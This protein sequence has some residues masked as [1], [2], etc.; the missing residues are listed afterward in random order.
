MHEF[1]IYTISGLTTGGIYAITASGLTLTYTTTGVFNFAHGAIGM[2]AA[3]CYWQLRFEW[4]WPAPIALAACLLVL[5]PLFG[6]FLERV[7]MRRLEG[8]SETTKLVVT[9]SLLLSLLALAL[10]VWD[11]TTFRSVRPLFGGHVF[12]VGTIRVSFNDAIV[13]ATALGVAVGLRLLLYRTRLGVSMRATVDDRSLAALNGADPRRS[14]MAAWSVGT[15]L[16]ALAGILV[17]PK[18]TLSPLPITLLIVNAYAAAVIGRLRSLPMTFV[19]ALLLGLANDYGVGYLP[20]ITDGQQYIRG[21]VAVIPVVVLFVALLVLPQSRLRG[22]RLLRTRELAPRPGWTGTL[23][24]AGAVVAGT[25]VVSTVLPKGDLFS[26]TKM[27]GVAIVGLSLVPLVGFAGR[28]SLCQLSFAA[29]GAIVVGH[30]GAGG[31]PVVL[32]WAML[33]AGA[34][35]AVIALPALRLAGIYLALATAAFAVAL[36][37]WVYGLPPFTVLGHRFDLFSGGTLNFE[38]PHLGP[39]H[40]DGDQSFFIFGSV[41]FGLVALLVVAIRRSERGQVLLATKDSPA[42]AATLGINLRWVTLGVFTLS[43]ALAG[44]GGGLYAMGLQSAS[45]GRF[46]FVQGLTLLLA[47]VVAGVNTVGAGLVCGLLLGAPFLTNL[48]PTLSQL[49]AV[50]VGLA[51]IGLGTNPNGFITAKVRPRFEVVGRAPA[52]LAGGVVA[53]AAVWALR[54]AGVIDNWPWVVLSVAAVGAMPVVADRLTGR[55]IETP[56]ERAGLATPLEWLGLTAPYRPEDVAAIDRVL[57]LP[58]VA[59]AAS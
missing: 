30:L 4:G 35:G 42:A 38:R 36:D 59:D 50:L 54:L 31:N 22:H 7:I 21:F 37:R 28:L 1:L 20:K 40:L 17:A 12:T 57:V 23:V 53:L 8:T 14:A 48:F 32:L 58:E 18:L 41:V 39:L 29:I 6:A 2:V 10:W 11:P 47:M 34:V 55:R 19:G 26:I 33:A 51:G 24:F 49:T 56:D 27:W 46:D 16:A 44:L 5:A 25:V 9:V 43:A 45:P 13:L 15:A 52:V 3:F